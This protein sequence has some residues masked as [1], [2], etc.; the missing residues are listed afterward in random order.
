M[1][2][3]P[4]IPLLQI[5][6]GSFLMEIRKEHSVRARRGALSLPRG[7]LCLSAP[8]LARRARGCPP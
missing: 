3:F 7:I 8:H 6:Y 5:F 1:E 4:E 2:E